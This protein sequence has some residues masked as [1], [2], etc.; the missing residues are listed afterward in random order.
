MSSLATPL[1]AALLLLAVLTVLSS[2]SA[3]VN[4]PQSGWYSGNPV[5]GPN[6]LTDLACAGSICYAAGQ[7]GTLLKSDDKGATWSGIVT[8]LT[9]DLTR[10]R[11]AG[12]APDH[13]MA[14]G[15]CALRRSDDGGDTFVRLPFTARDTGCRAGIV[16]FSF[17][18]EKIGYLV[19]SDSRVLA[20]ADG[21]RSFSRRTSVPGGA[22]DILCTA[23]P[24]CFTVGPSG[25]V[26]R[27]RDGGVSWTQVASGGAAL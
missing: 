1:R 2:A 9:L 26:E 23:E 14:G 18:T 24:T 5:L 13:V 11:F 8:G 15:G 16:S 27:T 20:T 19:L 4:N 12:G 22:T 17:P 25:L 3:G 6:N 10:V 7:F 21:G